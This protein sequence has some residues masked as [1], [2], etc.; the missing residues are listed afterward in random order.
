MAVLIGENEGAPNF[1]MRKF[2]LEAGG[3]TPYH[4]HDWEHVVYILEGSGVLKG[5]DGGR[6]LEAGSA[7]LV[8]PNEEHQFRA[9]DGTPLSFLCSIPKP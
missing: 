3:H 5:K 2:E 8:A 4:T 1:Y 9:D 6:R 7:V